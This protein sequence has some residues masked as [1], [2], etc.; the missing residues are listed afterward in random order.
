M[1]T[2]A[3]YAAFSAALFGVD[4]GQ[5]TSIDK[6]QR[7]AVLQAQL[8]EAIDALAETSHLKKQ[9]FI[10]TG[11]H[12]E[13]F[14]SLYPFPIQLSLTAGSLQ[15]ST[16][17]NSKL[18]VTN[19]PMRVYMGDRGPAIPDGLPPHLFQTLGLF[20]YNLAF[21]RG[22]IEWRVARPLPRLTPP[23][24][25]Y[26]SWKDRAD[27]Q[28]RIASCVLL[29]PDGNTREAHELSKGTMQCVT[30]PGESQMLLTTHTHMPPIPV[31]A[32]WAGCA[33][34]T[35]TASWTPG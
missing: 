6:A 7:V 12:I 32:A 13:A 17:A 28:P 21:R 1:T 3:E 33:R 8:L 14:R 18:S 11:Q 24:E 15:A 29:T 9:N 26:M 19:M 34:G 25:A 31:E 22:H 16:N 23:F 4:C 2:S 35:T 27:D 30:R 5:D 20:H 10:L